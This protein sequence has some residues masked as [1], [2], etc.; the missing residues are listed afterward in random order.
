M[1]MLSH[2]NH[3]LSINLQLIKRTEITHIVHRQTNAKSLKHA[4]C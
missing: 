2:R 1:D 3:D 4:V